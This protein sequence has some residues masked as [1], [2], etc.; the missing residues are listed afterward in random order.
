MYSIDMGGVV[1]TMTGFT[2]YIIMD[3]MP[4][5]SIG[6]NHPKGKLP[7]LPKAAS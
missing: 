1:A 6:Q 7:G 2:P 4:D 5:G 3:I